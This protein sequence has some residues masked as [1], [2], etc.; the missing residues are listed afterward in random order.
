[1]GPDL[2][3]RRDASGDPRRRERER[4][5]PALEHIVS[6]DPAPSLREA[7]ELMLKQRESAT[8]SS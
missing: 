7:G 6:V 3:P 2:R 8:S 5:A 4:R 1:M